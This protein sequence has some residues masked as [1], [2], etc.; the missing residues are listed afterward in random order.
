MQYFQIWQRLFYAYNKILEFILGPIFAQYL[1]DIPLIY[2]FK[3]SKDS[4]V[5]DLTVKT[6]VSLLLYY[7]YYLTIFVIE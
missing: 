6:Y 7:Y 2:C 1:L 4:I 3:K 5:M